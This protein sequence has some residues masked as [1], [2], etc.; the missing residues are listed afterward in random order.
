MPTTSSG[1]LLQ[2]LSSREEVLTDRGGML[3]VLW[4]CQ[5]QEMPTT[6][7]GDLLQM[8]SS[9]EEVLTDRGGMLQVL[10]S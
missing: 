2:M 5:G 3:Q 6:S 1:D 7:S 4:P 9:R 10:W 8:L